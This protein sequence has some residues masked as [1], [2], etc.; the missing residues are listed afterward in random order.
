MTKEEFIK[1]CVKNGYSYFENEEE[2]RVNKI[3]D[4]LLNEDWLF[5]YYKEDKEMK[6]Y[7]QPLPD[8]QKGCCQRII[9]T[10]IEFKIFIELKRIGDLSCELV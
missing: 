3:T 10:D 9:L 1:F 8:E 2:I 5:C 4:E 6:F 7:P